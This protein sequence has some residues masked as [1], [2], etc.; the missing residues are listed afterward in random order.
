MSETS[1]SAKVVKWLLAISTVV[2]LASSM[3]AIS[4]Y[5]DQWPS[6]GGSFPD[7]SRTFFNFV[8]METG[9]LLVLG[10]VTALCLAKLHYGKRLRI[11]SP[12]MARW[13]TITMF[14]FLC[15]SI[16]LPLGLIGVYYALRLKNSDFE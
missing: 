12:K 14:V 1:R 16:L 15:F 2:S 3:T 7:E 10:I 13:N 6:L 5:R 8:T 11:W 4:L 9:G